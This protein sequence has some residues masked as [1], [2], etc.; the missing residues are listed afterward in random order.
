MKQGSKGLAALLSAQT[1]RHLFYM[2]YSDKK[3]DDVCVWKC[4]GREVQQFIT[5]KQ[6]EQAIRKAKEMDAEDKVDVCFADNVFAQDDRCYI[7][8]ELGWY[9]GKIY[10]MEY[11]IFSQGEDETELRYE[12]ELTE[13]MQSHAKSR[14]GLWG[15]GKGDE[16]LRFINHA[17]V[18]DAQC[19][20]MLNGTAYLSLYD[21]EKDQG[22]M[23]C[24]EFAT[25]EF[26]WVSEKEAAFGD[27]AGEGAYSREDLD[28]VFEEGRDK[29][30]AGSEID[31]R[32]EPK[33]V[34]GQGD[35][36]E[37]KK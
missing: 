14:E 1:S 17:V 9:D 8:T 13:C 12:K 4:D 21:Y 23:G 31:F 18:N 15:D 22:R 6:V 26:R 19:V 11:L 2:A 32:I 30:V 24:Y 36:Y 16:D 25:G 7:Q 29:A 34:D 27:L 37:T 20:Y 33:A 5:K 28:A 10:R 3:G 35:F